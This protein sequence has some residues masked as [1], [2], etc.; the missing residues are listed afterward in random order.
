MHFHIF[1]FSTFSP[2]DSNGKRQV[3]SRKWNCIIGTTLCGSLNWTVALCLKYEG[4]QS[5]M[6]FVHVF[7]A[8][9][10]YLSYWARVWINFVVYRIIYNIQQFFLLRSFV[11]RKW[12]CGQGPVKA[13]YPWGGLAG[14]VYLCF[15]SCSTSTHACASTLCISM[16][17]SMNNKCSL[18]VSALCMQNT[19]SYDQSSKN[20]AK[21]PN[22][23]L[24]YRLL[25]VLLEKSPQLLDFRGPVRIK[26]S[27]LER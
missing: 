11:S 8:Y 27:A 26:F 10:L 1:K 18:K 9:R 20:P 21:P 5:H 17:S 14:L 3:Y 15:F 19:R 24:Q 6:Q 13:P 2:K 4:L 12:A 23:P 7:S 25:H 22:P 16:L